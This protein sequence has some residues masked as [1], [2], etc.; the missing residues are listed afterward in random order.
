MPQVRRIRGS[1]FRSRPLAPEVVDAPR[2]SGPSKVVLSASRAIARREEDAQPFSRENVELF[3]KD[4]AATFLD[5]CMQNPGW[6]SAERSDAKV[7]AEGWVPCGGQFLTPPATPSTRATTS[8]SPRPASPVSPRSPLSD[9]LPSRGSVDM[10][11]KQKNASSAR[12]ARMH[13]L[14]RGMIDH[15]EERLA[16][17]ARGTSPLLGARGQAVLP[18][19]PL[20]V[21]PLRMPLELRLRLA[22]GNKTCKGFR[23]PWLMAVQSANEEA[24][25]WPL[26]HAVLEAFEDTRSFDAAHPRPEG[27]LPRQ[28][29]ANPR[30]FQSIQDL[31]RR[32]EELIEAKAME[33]QCM[34]VAWRFLAATYDATPPEVLKML[35]HVKTFA[36]AQHGFTAA[37]RKELEQI[38][39][40]VL[41][42]AKLEV[43]PSP[44]LY[45]CWRG[46]RTTELSPADLQLEVHVRKSERDTFLTQPHGAF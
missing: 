18:V 8:T 21:D 45:S 16:E 22:A 2:S 44:T 26:R 31:L 29:Y 23:R 33:D 15:D 10:V 11:I 17:I 30:C 27:P 3:L 9:R 37:S 41:H 38:A 42:S 35:R 5:F 39:D 6:E 25:D 19:P 7:A 36:T 14:Q 43:R 4:R 46:D 40:E 28:E 34:P 32:A 24:R 13:E 1:A 20:E 12:R